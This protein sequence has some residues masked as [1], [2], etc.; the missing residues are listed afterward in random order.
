VKGKALKKL[1]RYRN[2]N[3]SIKTFHHKNKE[4]RREGVTLM[5]AT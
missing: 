4:K 1:R 2:F 5:D 3:I